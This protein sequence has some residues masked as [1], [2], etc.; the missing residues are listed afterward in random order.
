MGVHLKVE[1]AHWARA[2]QIVAALHRKGLRVPLSDVL[3][4]AVGVEERLA[5]V[6]RDKHFEVIRDHG[7]Q[8]LD[9][10]YIK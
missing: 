2:A 9:V 1:W 6:C 5:V 4:A 8:A 7:G 3:T 10:Q